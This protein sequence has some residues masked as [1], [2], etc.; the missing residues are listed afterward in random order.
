MARSGQGARFVQKMTAI[1]DETSRSRLPEAAQRLSMQ[2]VLLFMILGLMLFLLLAFGPLAAR[3]AQAV[4]V[5]YIGE[6]DLSAYHCDN[7]V[8]TVVKTICSA[9]KKPGVLVD[10]NG[11]WYGYC[12][13]PDS[14]V[15]AWLRAESKGKYFNS[16]I[17]GQYDC[18][19]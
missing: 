6:V 7:V 4:N 2:K 13:V 15:Q 11:T 16:A 1:P 14:V 18:R 8:S 17:K 10:L 5:K 9:K 19:K 3:P 12:G